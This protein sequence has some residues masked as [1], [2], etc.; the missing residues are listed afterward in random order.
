ME[1]DHIHTYAPLAFN[2]SI[3]TEATTPVLAKN[4]I[5]NPKLN[6]VPFLGALVASGACAT[7]LVA[8]GLPSWLSISLVAYPGYLLFKKAKARYAA[9]HIERSIK[10]NYDIVKSAV[11]SFH[12]SLFVEEVTAIVKSQ[13]GSQAWAMAAQAALE[14][15]DADNYLYLATVFSHAPACW[16]QAARRVYNNLLAG[17]VPAP[18]IAP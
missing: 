9:S 18:A 7:V 11:E 14:K 12:V 15:P 13:H 10:A 4:S 16:R 3:R 17:V 2:L 1:H 5:D 6:M 8:I